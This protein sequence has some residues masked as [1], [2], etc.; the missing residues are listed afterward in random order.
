[1][2][3]NEVILDAR[4]ILDEYTDDGA[5]IASSELPDF[6][7]SAIRFADMG[8]KELYSIGRIQKTLEI[9]NKPIENQL[10]NGFNIEEFTGDDKYY[11]NE[12]GLPN[13]KSYH[14]EADQTHE[15]IIQEYEGGSWL[16]L[17]TIDATV[18]TM[19]A[20]KGNLS[21]TTTGNN[22]R[23]KVTGESFYR[24]INRALFL[25]KFNTDANVPNYN[26]WVRYELPTDFK[27][28][29]MVVEEYPE[30]NYGNLATYKFEQP[31]KFY[32]NYDFVGKIRI[33][34]KPVPVTLTTVDDELEIDDIVAK[35]LSFYV[36]SWLSP[37]SN[38]SMTNPLFQK[39]LELKLENTTSEPM[40]EELITDVYGG[41][42][43]ANL[44]TS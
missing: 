40:S 26:P 10:A 22:I 27:S 35:A 17:V 18:T 14:I 19:T 4:A 3:V 13:I 5:V 23:I 12:N 15:I 7:A 11:P 28:L 2:T 31:N 6:I 8:Q 9:V 20:Y 38:Q 24:T 44:Y 25:Y 37:Y 30:Q 29:D 32:Y 21:P 41:Y 39:F 16:D 42:T 36:A 43:Y 34:Y 1:M 33:I